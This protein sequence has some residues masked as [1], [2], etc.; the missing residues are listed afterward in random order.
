MGDGAYDQEVVGEAH[1]QSVIA[2]NVSRRDGAGVR[3]PV[4]TILVPDPGNPH[5]PN[6]VSVRIGS[7]KVGQLPREDADIWVGMLEREGL[8]GQ[9]VRAKGVIVGGHDAERRGVM[10]AA[11]YSVRLDI[12]PGYELTDLRKV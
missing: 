8:R 11:P 12:A 5:D 7:R 9:A 6:A 1:Y 3:V 10:V 2:S 4:H